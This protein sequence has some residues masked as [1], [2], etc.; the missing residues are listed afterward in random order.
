MLIAICD[1]ISEAVKLSPPAD[2]DLLNLPYR[3]FEYYLNPHSALQ[4]ELQRSYS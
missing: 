1:E 4:V 3:T 2:A